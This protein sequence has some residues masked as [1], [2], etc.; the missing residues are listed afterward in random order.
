[1]ASLAAV[2]RDR[3]TTFS[4]TPSVSGADNA[5]FDELEGE[6]DSGEIEGA[7][8]PS[9][10][11]LLFDNFEQETPESGG[12]S[13]TGQEVD[14][15]FTSLMQIARAKLQQL[16][17]SIEEVALIADYASDWMSL[18]Y[19]L[20]PAFFAFRTG[21]QLVSNHE[22]MLEQDVHPVE[23]ARYLLSI[24]ITAQQVPVQNMSVSLYRGHGVTR[25][26]DAVCRT[27][28]HNIIGNN[29]LV[30]TL[31]GLET[32]MLYVRLYVNRSR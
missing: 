7:S 12:S 9:H 30:G 18:Y 29:A 4:G 27:V 13:D 28:E 21:D 32:A 31:E 2:V 6:L 25:F 10:L 15:L 20:F 14:R 23:L 11:R 17:P 26:V 24:A 8:P 3:Q 5:L 22:R 1:M 19:T 16:L